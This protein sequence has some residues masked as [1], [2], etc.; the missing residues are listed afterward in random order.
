MSRGR[1]GWRWAF[2]IYALI[3][4]T[5]THWPRLR[6]EGPMPRPDLWLHVGAFGAWA[7]LCGACAWW[8]A[9]SAWRNLAV[10]WLVG[11]LYAALDEG[12]QLIPALGRFAAWDDYAANVVGVTLGVVAIAIAGRMSRRA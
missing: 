1:A 9:W 8:G 10:T 7:A 5:A 6:I 2:A 3:L 4:F 12:L 11:V